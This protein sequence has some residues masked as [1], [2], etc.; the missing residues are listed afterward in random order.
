MKRIDLDIKQNGYKI[1][2][3]V[4]I[5]SRGEIV[6]IS[7]RSDKVYTG[8]KQFNYAFFSFGHYFDEIKNSTVPLNR[9]IKSNSKELTVLSFTN[10]K[11]KRLFTKLSE[12]SNKPELDAK[13]KLTYWKTLGF[14]CKKIDQISM[15]SERKKIIVSLRGGLAVLN[16]LEIPKEEI[17]LIDC[18]RVVLENPYSYGAGLSVSD[19]LKYQKNLKNLAGKKLKIV[20]VCIAT[21]ITTSSLLL[22]LYLKN[23]KPISIEIITSAVTQQGYEMISRLAKAL[24]F[25]LKI[26][27]G[28]MFYRVGDFKKF[29]KDTILNGRGRWV[30]GNISEILKSFI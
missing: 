30:F 12:I 25:E 24:G 16:Y 28:A 11:V 15:D 19:T 26:I 6:D 22:D 21:G 27:T 17:Y 5:P 9:R 14:I 4:D 3:T 23:S 18:K 8:P 29:R 20:E 13:D 2:F 10:P 7:S 1:N